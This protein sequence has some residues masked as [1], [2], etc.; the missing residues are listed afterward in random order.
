MEKVEYQEILENRIDEFY[1]R[2]CP[3]G[4]QDLKKAMEVAFETE[5]FKKDEVD[6]CSYLKNIFLDQAESTRREWD[7][8][9]SIDLVALVY[10]DVL[11]DSKKWFIEQGWSEEIENIYIESNYNFTIEEFNNCL[12]LF[13]QT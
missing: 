11:E 1:A 2:V 4:Y 6:V 12:K 8:Y 13:C 9:R 5:I 10:D 3:I 7:E